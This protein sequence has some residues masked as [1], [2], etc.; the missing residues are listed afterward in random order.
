M[1]I[2]KAGV[3]SLVEVDSHVYMPPGQTTARTPIAAAQAS[4]ALQLA[5]RKVGEAISINPGWLDSTA[6][7]EGHTLNPGTPWTPQVTA[8]DECRFARDGYFLRIGQLP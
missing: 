2:R 8:T 7:Q 1:E 6:K 4:L 3:T 5:L